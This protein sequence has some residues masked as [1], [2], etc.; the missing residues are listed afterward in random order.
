MN[1]KF[2]NKSI[3]YAVAGIVITMMGL[4]CIMHYFPY[5]ALLLLVS[6]VLLW[7]SL[8]GF[9]HGVQSLRQKERP[10]YFGI[11]GLPLNL[12]VLILSG[13]AIMPFLNWGNAPGLYWVVIAA[14]PIAVLFP[15]LLRWWRSEWGRANT[16]FGVLSIGCFCVLVSVVA[17]PQIFANK[18]LGSC[19]FEFCDFEF[20]DFGLYDIIGLLAAV[21]MLVGL[22]FGFLGLYRQEEPKGYRYIGFFLNLFPF[23]FFWCRF[24]L[25]FNL[26]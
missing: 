17:L 26:R 16:R 4:L 1:A 13:L 11:I 3:G 10:K 9:I 5:E 14:I 20:C 18:F 8:K 6:P 25:I 15:V 19:D 22:S 2:G 23:L 12:L 24:F 7:L 21:L